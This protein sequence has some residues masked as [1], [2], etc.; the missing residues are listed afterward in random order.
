MN[1]R[2]LSGHFRIKDLEESISVELTHLV[3]IFQ[4]INLFPQ[5]I[6]PAVLP[7]GLLSQGVHPVL[8][9]PKVNSGERLTIFHFR[10]ESQAN[11]EQGKK[12]G[13]RH[14][15]ISQKIG[16]IQKRCRKAYINP[17]HF[18]A[19]GNGGATDAKGNKA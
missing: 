11:E 18:H 7:Y 16:E 4:N 8:I 12:C 13:N 9:L 19:N 17:T 2:T 10:R 14:A 1:L 5:N 6:I 3:V 15:G